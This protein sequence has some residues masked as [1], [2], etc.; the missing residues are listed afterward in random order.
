MQ[1]DKE[2]VKKESKLL[3]IIQ[4]DTKLDL[5]T[6]QEYIG[7][8]RVFLDDL[9]INLG[10]TSIELDEKYGNGIDTWLDFLQYAPIRKYFQSMKDEQLQVKVD[11]G[12]MAGTKDV[13]GL[14]K[15]MDEKGPN[16]NNSNF[17]MV[18]LPEKVVY[19]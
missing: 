10:C 7:M 4:K 11:M 12:L 6:K 2:K 16:I 17:I 18:R 8:A 13:V 14:K 1:K 15:I 19:E 3:T 9:K 5:E